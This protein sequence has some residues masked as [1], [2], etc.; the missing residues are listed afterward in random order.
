MP[1]CTNCIRLSKQCSLIS[2]TPASLLPKLNSRLKTTPDLS[3]SSYRPSC[4]P[5]DFARLFPHMTSD[6]VLDDELFHH[7]T[8][9]T[10]AA[11]GGTRALDIWNSKVPQLALE[12][13]FLMH[14][15]LAVTALH[16]ADL[17]PER[18]SHLVARASRHESLALPS[19][20]QIISKITE[21]NCH[22]IF[23]F[24][25]FVI[26]Y[27]LASLDSSESQNTIPS[28]TL[29]AP[30]WMYLIRGVHGLLY[31][32]WKWLLNGPFAPLLER[33][34][35]PI[36]FANNPDDGHLAALLPL[37]SPPDPILMEDQTVLDTC[38]GAFNELRR[39]CALPYSP[40]KTVDK[41]AAATIWPGTISPAYIQLL[42][43]RRPEALIILAHYSVL[44][45][46]VPDCWYFRR[47]AKQLL[48]ATCQCLSRRWRTWIEW[49]LEQMNMKA[50]I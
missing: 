33:T 7:Y 44:V 37:F 48:S 15:L 23:T 10:Y 16:L 39:T 8:T 31:T 32:N 12:H 25:G 4:S 19:F 13:P 1:S 47:L 49:P 45:N 38:R 24:S 34:R 30:N 2:I 35:F 43:E 27:A 46:Q 20:R 3:L 42:R 26:P 50:S 40:C 29:Q 9:S 22:A 11:I 36:D 41:K 21:Q 6:D 17:N 18:Y 28:N 5:L 14:G